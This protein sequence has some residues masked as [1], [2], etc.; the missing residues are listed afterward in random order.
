MY[1]GC[2]QPYHIVFLISKQKQISNSLFVNYDILFHSLRILSTPWTPETE[3]LF[4]K[5]LHS[6]SAALRM[7]HTHGSQLVAVEFLVGDDEPRP[8]PPLDGVAQLL[9]HP[10]QRQENGLHVAAPSGG[11]SLRLS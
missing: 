2:F 3:E 8:R 1:L 5:S 7:I 6:S 10:P 4:I 11:L 9:L